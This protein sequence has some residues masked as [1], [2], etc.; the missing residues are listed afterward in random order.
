MIS[1]SSTSIS[2]PNSLR[3]ARSQPLQVP[4]PTLWSPTCN[5]LREV[6][7]S[8]SFMLIQVEIKDNRVSTVRRPLGPP[9]DKRCSRW[10]TRGRR[11]RTAPEAPN[12]T[13]PRVVQFTRLRNRRGE[14]MVELVAT[15]K[16]T[17][18]LPTPTC[19]KCNKFKWCNES[20][21]SYNKTPTRSRCINNSCCRDNR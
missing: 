18:P 6:R 4:Q 19:A 12:T 2:R 7:P 17:A 9:A 1:S 15:S 10:C 5:Q 21:N 14:S 11:W 13:D 20:N 3:T 16:C 8:A